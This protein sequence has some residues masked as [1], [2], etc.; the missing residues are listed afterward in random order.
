MRSRYFHG[1]SALAVAL[2]AGWATGAWADTPT[3]GTEVGS[4]EVVAHT[5]SYIAR[6]TTA[7]P[8]DVVSTQDLQRQGN[9]TIL[10]LVKTI[11]ASSSGLGESNRYNGGAGTA[12][13]N[14]RGFGSNRTLVLFNGHRMPDSTAAAFQGGGV[15]LNS[16]PTAAIGRVEILKDGAAA[17]YGS[18]AIGGVV[19]FISRT[20]LNGFDIDGQYTGISGSDGDYQINGAYGHRFDNGNV[21]LTAGYRHRSRLDIHERDW[22]ILPYYAG[23]AGGFSGNSNPG[24]N[25]Q[26]LQNPPAP[27]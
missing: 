19:N 21:L 9:P 24:N 22:A 8:V 1:A 26:N 15:N 4:V 11:T 20:D 12:S 27:V 3:Q 10:Q 17:T 23:A 16:I 6:E 7:L 18:E 25:N 2:T 5:G 14:L 13:I